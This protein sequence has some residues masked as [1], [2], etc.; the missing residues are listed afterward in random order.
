MSF[1]YQ[2]LRELNKLEEM[3]RDRPLGFGDANFIRLNCLTKKFEGYD[4][5]KLRKLVEEDSRTAA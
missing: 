1:T 4:I 3:V 5:D 2:D